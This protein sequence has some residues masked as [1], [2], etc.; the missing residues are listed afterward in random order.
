MIYTI[1]NDILSVSV[2]SLGAELWSINYG[3]KE[4]LW[5]GDKKYWGGRAPIMFP[6]CGRLFEGKYTYGG[7]EYTM[8]NHGIA[9][10]S[11]FALKEIC[12]EKLVL[13]LKSTEKTREHYPFDFTFDVCFSLEGGKLS[14]EYIVTNDQ[15]EGKLIFALGGH[16]A[17]NVPYED[18]TAFE[19][20]Y[21]EFSDFCPAKR[22][23][24][25]PACFCT[26]EDKLY[27]CEGTRKIDLSHDLFDD[28]A[29]FLYDVAKEIT[30]G[31]DK[32][33]I[34]VNMKYEGMKYIGL[35][36]APKTDAPYICIEPWLSIP[37]GQGVIDDLETKK[38][39]VCL[40]PLGTYKN[41]YTIEFTKRS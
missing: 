26:Y 27:R 3:G 25:S 7:K 19:D 8:P 20:Y 23:D 18:G 16:P 14:V 34:S 17:F 33:P 37:A 38:E 21:V 30:L 1:K 5:Q 36:H 15:I 22:V 40:A 10:S 29:I 39:M 4:M 41:G 12:D 9:R 2:S 13:T 6:I 32:S 24:F 28:D 11:E 35:W 31:S